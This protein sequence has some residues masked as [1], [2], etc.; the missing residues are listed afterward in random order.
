MLI[1]IS[2]IFKIHSHINLN[3]KNKTKLSACNVT[4]VLLKL[5]K[6]DN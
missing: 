1:L 4:T 3:Q 2:V 5:K 6:K